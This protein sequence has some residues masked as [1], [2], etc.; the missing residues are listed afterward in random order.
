MVEKFVGSFMTPTNRILKTQPITNAIK[1]SLNPII[2]LAFTQNIDPNKTIDY[3]RCYTE[4][5]WGEEKKFNWKKKIQ[6]I[7]YL[8]IIFHSFTLIYT[9]II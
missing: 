5:K 6:S 8:F 1:Q 9:K 3:I 2:L 7:I 4:G